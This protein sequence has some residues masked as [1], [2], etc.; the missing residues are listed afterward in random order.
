LSIWKLNRWNTGLYDWPAEDLARCVHDL[1]YVSEEYGVYKG[2]HLVTRAEY[3]DNAARI[4]GK[5]VRFENDLE[6]RV[7]Y[8]TPYNMI[9]APHES[10]I[11][12]NEFDD[13]LESWLNRL[14]V[15]P[16][17]FDDFFERV[18]GLRTHSR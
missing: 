4:D 3:D 14:L 2:K 18:R 5:L 16:S 10:P 15:E 9:I 12:N 11:N 13:E 7:R 17:T 1:G 8:I 6:L